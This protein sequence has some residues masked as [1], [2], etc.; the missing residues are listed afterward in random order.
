[1]AVN[2]ISINFA[3]FQFGGFIISGA[4]AWIG[5]TWKAE[6]RCQVLDW[7]NEFD[8]FVVQNVGWLELTGKESRNMT[9]IEE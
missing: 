6:E 1:M 7:A 9:D 2:W 3:Q 4:F 8:F 5:A